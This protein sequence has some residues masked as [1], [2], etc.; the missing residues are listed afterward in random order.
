MKA[1]NFLL[2][3]FGMLYFHLYLSLYLLI[4]YFFFD[5]NIVQEQVV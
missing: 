2:T 4:F 3:T 1:V 5:S